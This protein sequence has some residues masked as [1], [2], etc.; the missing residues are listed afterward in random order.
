[1]CKL[2]QVLMSGKSSRCDWFMFK[3]HSIIQSNVTEEG[4]SIENV[5]KQL[6]GVP[7][8]SVR[9]VRLIYHEITV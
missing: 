5:C 3:V 1:M 9:L 8:R 7:E 2:L 4:A 6:R